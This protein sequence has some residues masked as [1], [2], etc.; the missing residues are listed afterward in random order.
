MGGERLHLLRHE[1]EKGGCRLSKLA[2]GSP[3]QSRS[4]YGYVGARAGD[5]LWYLRVGVGSVL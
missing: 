1:E 4:V 5:M 2:W 3:D